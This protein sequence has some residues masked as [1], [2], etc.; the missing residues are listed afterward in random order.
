M[1]AVVQVALSICV[2]ILMESPELYATGTVEVEHRITAGAG[3]VGMGPIYNER[4]QVQKHFVQRY[5]ST[6]SIGGNTLWKLAAKKGITERTWQS[7]KDRYRAHIFLNFSMSKI[8][9][10]KAMGGEAWYDK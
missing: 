7:M 5:S 2:F 9:E 10:L 6:Y 8:D 3:S 1:C 4:G